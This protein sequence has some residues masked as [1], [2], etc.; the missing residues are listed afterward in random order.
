MALEADACVACGRAVTWD[1]SGLQST[2]SRRRDLIDAGGLGVTFFS[3][4]NVN[5]EYDVVREQIP[6]TQVPW[7]WGRRGA[8]SR[9]GPISRPATARTSRSSHTERICRT[10]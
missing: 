8:V 3:H 1:K 2:H 7:S 4:L 10:R 5:A 6:A 9:R